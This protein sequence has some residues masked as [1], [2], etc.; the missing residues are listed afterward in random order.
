MNSSERRLKLMLMLQQGKSRKTVEEYADYFGVSKR[1]IFR[2]FNA[3]QEINVPITWDKYSGYGVMPGY[4]IPPLMFSSHELATIIVGLNFVKSQVDERLVEDAKGVEVKIHN[5]L[6]NELK[7]FMESLQERTVVDPYLKFGSEKK[8]GGNWYTISSAISQKKRIQFSYEAKSGEKKIRKIDPYLLVFYKDHWNVIGFSH[9]RSDFRNFILDRV[10]EIKII[11]ENFVEKKN[12]EIEGLIFR[13]E[14]VSQ[15]I[16]V[17]V[18]KE[19]YKRFR[20]NLPTNKFKETRVG[21]EKI[22]VEFEVDNLSFINNWL[23][24]FGNSIKVEGPEEL[25]TLRKELLSKMLN[26]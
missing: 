10:S 15:K 16:V 23:L 7:E 18:D 6:P 19:G 21:S 2:D 11:D 14:A 3:L 22:K 24:Q 1:T 25:L 13:L 5:V 12:I 9:L 4:K 8:K 17:L 20:A 26:Q